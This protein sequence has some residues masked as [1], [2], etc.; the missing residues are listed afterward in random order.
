M[1]CLRRDSYGARQEEFRLSLVH[2][3][4]LVAYFEVREGRIEVWGDSETRSS[5]MSIVC[6]A[7]VG[8][9]NGSLMRTEN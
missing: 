4:P 7:N 8:N 5:T 1:S 2:G 6:K 3:F 9:E